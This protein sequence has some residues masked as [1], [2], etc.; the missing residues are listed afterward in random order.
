M[1][2]RRPGH[3]RRRRHPARSAILCRPTPRPATAP[4]PRCASRSTASGSSSGAAT[5]NAPTT[6]CVAPDQRHAYDLVVWRDGGTHRGAGTAN[7]D[8][9][10][11]GQRGPR[12]PPRA[13]VVAAVD[14]IADNEPLTGRRAT[15]TVHPAGNHVLIDVGHGEYLLLAHF[16]QGSVRPSRSAIGWRRGSCSG[17]MR[18]LGELVGAAHPR[19]PPGLGRR[20]LEGL[21]LPLAFSDLVVDGERGGGGRARYRA[22][23]WQPADGDG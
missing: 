11:W 12:P 23:S 16:Q 20:A 7:D 2:V 9:W 5:P 3:D 21:G 6:T 17:L 15:P 8:Y 13:T 1:V 18:Q 10:A 4:R 22:S 14:G 19:P